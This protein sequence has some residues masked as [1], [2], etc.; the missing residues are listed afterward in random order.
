MKKK[1]ALFAM[2]LSIL[3]I[4]I[5][6]EAVTARGLIEGKSTFYQ[7]IS[8]FGKYFNIS[9]SINLSFESLKNVLFIVA[10]LL[11]FV[12][13]FILFENSK[14]RSIVLIF[15][16]IF[17]ISIGFLF[18]QSYSHMFLMIV[19]CFLFTSN[20]I[21]QFTESIKN[22]I[23]M[24]VI[25]LTSFI[26]ISNC[27]YLLAHLLKRSLWEKWGISDKLIN[28]MINM[29]RINLFLF[30]LWLIPYIILLIK[31]ITTNSKNT[32]RTAN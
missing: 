26:F 23:N 15:I 2:I 21:I 27:Y 11:L 20:I 19:L 22:K 10:I 4:I 32:T 16:N 28:E 18:Y 29:S 6:I 17:G 30:S 8:P 13:N 12:P 1:I 9:N 14:V 3:L 24:L 7:T 25:I 5:S 31:E